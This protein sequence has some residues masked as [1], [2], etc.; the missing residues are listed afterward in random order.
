MSVTAIEPMIVEDTPS[1]TDA[2]GSTAAAVAAAAA[3]TPNALHEDIDP[4]QR[5]RALEKL[6]SRPTPFGSETGKLK[7]AVFEPFE[8]VSEILSTFLSGM[9]CSLKQGEVYWGR[10][11]G[12]AGHGGARHESS[13]YALNPVG[14][15]DT[16]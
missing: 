1:K 13:A 12:G 16:W 15:Y 6:V 10:E 8:N 2:G 3:A 14:V 5:W 11:R 4:S 7:V 9:F